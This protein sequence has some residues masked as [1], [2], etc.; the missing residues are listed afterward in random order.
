VAA[1]AR[2]DTHA[3]HEDDRFVGLRERGVATD[4]DLGAFARQTTADQSRHARL[5][6]SEQV[7]DVVDW[8]VGRRLDDG[9]RVAEALD[10]GFLT[11]A[12]DDDLI[13][14]NGGHRH[15]KVATGGLAAGHGNGA[16]FARIT[17]GTDTNHH[18]RR[19]RRRGDAGDT[20]VA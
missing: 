2:V 14:L 5:T 13:E 3:V 4:A 16:R 8:G 7:G 20:V 10:F 9:H 19:T 11:G 15:G 12:R 1:T 18:F 17:D 6:R